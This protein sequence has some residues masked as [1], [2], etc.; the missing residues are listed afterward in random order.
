[1]D[2]FCLC[3][4]LV[5]EVHGLEDGLTGG[6]EEDA[7]ADGSEGGGLLVEGDVVA[8]SGEERGGGESCDAGA[9][10]ADT[11]GHG[12]FPIGGDGGIIGIGRW[13]ARRQYVERG[14]RRSGRR[15]RG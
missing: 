5:E 9:G 10:D 13:W 3:G 7:C 11:E 1:M 2:G 12:G 8:G 6:L 14:H 4:D 15:W